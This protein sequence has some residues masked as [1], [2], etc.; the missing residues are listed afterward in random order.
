M[1]QMMNEQMMIR[2][3]KENRECEEAE[4]SRRLG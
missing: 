3:R 2:A 1:D 4:S